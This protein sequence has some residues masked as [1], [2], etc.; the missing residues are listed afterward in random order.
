MYIQYVCVCVYIYIYIY[1]SFQ[2]NIYIQ[3]KYFTEL[4]RDLCIWACRQW[5]VHLIPDE[6]GRES[7]DLCDRNSCMYVMCSADRPEL[8]WQLYHFAVKHVRLKS[9]SKPGA[10]YFTFVS[11]YDLYLALSGDTWRPLD[12]SLY[13]ENIFVTRDICTC[14]FVHKQTSFLCDRGPKS[15]ASCGSAINGDVS[16]LLMVL[17]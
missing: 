13:L 9:A 6:A 10:N 12:G 11:P 2:P 1:I 7:G 15:H 8:H 4:N 5:S 17:Y 16:P 14:V 3:L